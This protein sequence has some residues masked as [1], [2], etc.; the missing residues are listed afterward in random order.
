MNAITG[1]VGFTDFISYDIKHKIAYF[2]KHI[3]LKESLIF[4]HR[5]VQ[6]QAKLDS[7]ATFA[8]QPTQGNSD[9]LS[10]RKHVYKKGPVVAVV[11]F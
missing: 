7:A 9:W 5:L 4:V 8:L 11:G 6:N 3:F 10:I 2:H 1:N